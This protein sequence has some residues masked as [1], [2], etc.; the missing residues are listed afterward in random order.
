MG[1]KG[2]ALMGRSAALDA[3]FL[4]GGATFI[5]FLIAQA[6]LMLLGW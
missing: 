4:A 6:L 3:A 2:F 1:M 5:V